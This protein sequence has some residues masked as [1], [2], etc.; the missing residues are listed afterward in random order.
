MQRIPEADLMD[1]EAQARAYA[2]ADFAEAHQQLITLFQQRWPGRE[3]TGRVVDLGCGPADISIRFA[4]A[5]P[6]CE[7]EGVDGAD[8][9]L[10]HAVKAV[11]A[12]G[13]SSRI[14]LRNRYL[15]D[16]ALAQQPFDAV[17]SN[18]LLHHLQEPMTLWQTVRACARQN[19][20]AG[21][22]VFVMDLMRPASEAEVTQLVE[23]YA[24]S[25]PD[26]LQHDFRRSLFAAYR[27]DEVQ[28]QLNAAGLNSLTV[29]AVSD[30]HL[31]V[32]GLL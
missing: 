12:A 24:A 8:A 25:E 3:V 26:L 21:T 31:L 4:R 10:A 19:S 6:R 7:I 17:I 13:L 28:A 22:P 5:F 9:M 23:Q 18:S 32:A 30:R 20:A 14:T 2:E 15:P 1:D 27:I 11:A 29:E 16:E